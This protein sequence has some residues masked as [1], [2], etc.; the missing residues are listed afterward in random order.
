MTDV[1]YLDGMD[2]TD[3]ATPDEYV[4][5][6]RAAYAER[7]RGADA[8]PRT[9]LTRDDVPGMMTGYLAILPDSG[10][11]GG[12]MYAAGFGASDAWF[13][14]PLFDADEGEL[15]ALVDGGS[16]NPFKTGA[17]GAVGVDELAREDASELA[18]IGTGSQARGQLITAATV[19]DLDAVR[20]F[21]PTKE[22][23]ESF[24]AD[25]D[26]ELQATV[27]A[28][29]DSTA[30][31]AGA[32]EDIEAGTH[33]TAMGQYDPEKREL[34]GETVARAK[35]VPD[36]RERTEQDAGSF[37]LAREAGL[38]DEDHVHAELGEVVVGDAPGRTD[39][40]EITVFDSGGTGIETVGAASMLYEMARDEDLGTMMEFFP[41]SESMI[42][43]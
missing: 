37:I 6:V 33:I 26:E 34:P 7:G 12:Y 32:D 18:V 28:V 15:L 14:T 25:F 10:Y 31:V 16:M 8:R 35:Y 17:A 19:R 38:V 3:L 21:S 41:A 22:H 24:A 23:R 30:A 4:S 29:P 43:N 27:E 1:R 39:D 42:G 40:R 20:V 9:K 36:L 11:M 2:V 13:V 5:A